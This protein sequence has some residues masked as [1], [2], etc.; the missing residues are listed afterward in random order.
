MQKDIERDK[1]PQS[2]GPK[3]TTSL[4]VEL[5]WQ[6]LDDR[7]HPHVSGWHVVEEQVVS[8]GFLASERVLFGR[9]LLPAFKMMLLTSFVLCHPF[10]L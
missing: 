7:F 3:S 4:R 10:G 1:R 2:D 9:K 8:W 5:R 6:L